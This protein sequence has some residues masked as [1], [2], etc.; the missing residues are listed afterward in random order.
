[1]KT[2]NKTVTAKVIRVGRYIQEC[3]SSVATGTV[4]IFDN[5]DIFQATDK[6]DCTT[7]F[8]CAVKEGDTITYE[9]TADGEII[10]KEFVI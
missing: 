1:M 5:G 6:F 9:R 4:L 8:A 3:I 2:G 7:N 10:L